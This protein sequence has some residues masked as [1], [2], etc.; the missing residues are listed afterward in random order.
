MLLGPDGQL[1]LFPARDVL[2]T[3]VP[4]PLSLASSLLAGGLPALDGTVDRYGYVL[5]GAANI[6]AGI[7]DIGRVHGGVAII[8]G[9]C[10]VQGLS[11]VGARG[12]GIYLQLLGNIE[13]YFGG[14][15]LVLGLRVLSGGLGMGDG[16]S[17]YD[18]PF[19]P[20]LQTL[21]RSAA[22]L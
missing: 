18:V 11:D 10:G 13:V 8:G 20:F 16:V 12:V 9:D 22:R 4:L 1:V 3:V 19:W 15:G 2:Y 6:V 5:L 17:V 7:G 14:L 21:A